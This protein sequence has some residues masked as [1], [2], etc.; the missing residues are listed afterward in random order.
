MEVARPPRLSNIS[1][2]L[3]GDARAEDDDEEL[4]PAPALSSPS[5]ELDDAAEVARRAVFDKDR[6]ASFLPDQFDRFADFMDARLDDSLIQQEVVFEEGGS[7]LGDDVGE[8]EIDVDD[9]YE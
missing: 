5:K 7:Y 8:Q 2:K 3:I 1:L 6:R 9:G 4:S